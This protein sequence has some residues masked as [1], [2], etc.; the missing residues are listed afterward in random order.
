MTVGGY[1]TKGQWTNPDGTLQGSNTTFGIFYTASGEGPT[2]DG[3]LKP[4]VAVPALRI[5]TA[6]SVDS[7]P[8]SMY[9]VEDGVHLVMSGTSMAVPHMTG[10]VALMLQKDPTITPAEIRNWVTA[11][12]RSDSLTGTVPNYQ[13]GN[14]RLDLDAA[15][16][17]VPLYTN[18]SGARS[19]PDGAIVKLPN[20]VVTAGISQL[21]DRFYIESPDRSCG[22]QVRRL[23]GDSPAEGDAVTVTGNVGLVSGE[24][25]ILNSSVT[26]TGSGV[27]PVPIGIGNRSLG[28]GGQGAWNPGVTGSHGL[29]NMGLLA[30]TWGRVTSVGTDYFY[31]DDGS[32]LAGLSGSGVKVRCPGLTKP[33]VGK[34][35]VVSGISSLE[36]SGPTTYPLIR[37]RKQSDLLYY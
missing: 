10:A 16:A 2:R 20:Q 32:K 15:F 21:V 12:A 24:R 4:E 31:V 8:S 5:A 35:A 22:I 27:L 29:N 13:W 33:S 3:R 17:L 25:A 36:A 14:G 11:T 9:I 37:V 30:K 7:G 26:R 23:S 28:G 6:R 1:L 19:Q 34:Y 18:I